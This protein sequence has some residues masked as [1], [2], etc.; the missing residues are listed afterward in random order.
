MESEFQQRITGTG[1]SP[2]YSGHPGSLVFQI[3]EISPDL[4]AE[5]H[6]SDPLIKLDA[7]HLGSTG[8]STVRYEKFDNTNSSLVPAPPAT[9]QVQLLVRDA[10]A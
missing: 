9:G 10:S 3:R 7:A 8:K 1:L 4:P 5:H 2:L 6:D